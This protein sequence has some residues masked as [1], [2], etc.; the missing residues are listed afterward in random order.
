MI[1]SS[2]EGRCPGC[3]SRLEGACPGCKKAT[4]EEPAIIWRRSIGDFVTDILHD[5]GKDKARLIANE[6]IAR[7]GGAATTAQDRE[8]AVG[9]AY[10]K[11]SAEMSEDFRLFVRT[12]SMCGSVPEPVERMSKVFAEVRTGIRKGK[13]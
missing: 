4:V 6:I 13:A 9:W 11:P 8:A 1:D 3:R 5:L 10:G 12:G 7:M 2:K